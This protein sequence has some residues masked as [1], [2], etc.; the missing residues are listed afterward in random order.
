MLIPSTPLWTRLT[1]YSYYLEKEIMTFALHVIDV[2][3]SE[4]MII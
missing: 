2:L 4:I 3:W 1:V